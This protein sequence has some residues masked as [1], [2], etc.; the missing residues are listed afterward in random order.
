M[1]SRFTG[2]WRHPDFM[3]LWV[4]ETISLFGTQVTLL[5]LPLV[6][7]LTLNATAAEMGYLGAAERAPFLLVGL[8]AGVW[9]DRLRRRPILIWADLGRAALL[10]SIPVVA[11]LGVLGIEQLYVIG[12]LVGI[13]TVFFDVA[14]MSFLPVLVRRER[15]VEGNSK[16]EMSSSIALI[17]GPGVAGVLVQLIT[18]PIAI[19]VDAAS[20]VASALFLRSIRTS[21]PDPA[22][23]AQGQSIWGEIGEGLRVVGGNPLLRSIAGCTGTSNLFSN[24]TFTV[25]VLYATRDLR[26]QPAALGLIFA[27]LGPGSL[28]GA[29][30]AGRLAR[31]LGLGATIVG[32]IIV[33]G[34]AG[35]IIPLASGPATLTVPLM[36]TSMFVWGLMGPVYNI[37]QVSL[38]Q[39][40][41][42]DRLQGRMNA[43]MRF[44]VWGTMPV[45]SLLGGFL[46]STIG[47]RPTLAV[48][49]IGALLS[50]LWVLLS[51]VRTLREQ[52][53]PAEESPIVAV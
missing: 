49:A 31:R 46:G 21:E 29:V 25:F 40:I 45:G 32:A 37:N 10:V 27:A 20:Y 1:R 22:P 44:L 30:L 53:A 24:V 14:Y 13:L 9:V 43:S 23:R 8:F 35:L 7:A 26:L 11:V 5:A 41:V 18:A 3:K 36:M 6:A 50:A 2:L 51:P 38:R 48:G 12:F 34:A 47:L 17:A 19:V 33:G 16:L 39:A 4:G 52:P 28:L 42:P 15:L